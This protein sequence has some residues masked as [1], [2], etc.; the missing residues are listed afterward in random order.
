VTDA[1]ETGVLVNHLYLAHGRE[2][3]YPFMDEGIVR[4]SFAFEPG[5]RYRKG[6][7]VKPLLK[8]ILEQHSLSSI[9][10]KPKGPSVFND[11]LYDWM[12]NGSMRDMVRSIE[13]P[14]F[15]SQSD[16]RKLL[17]VPDWDPLDEPNWFLWNLLTFDLFQKRVVH[18]GYFR[19]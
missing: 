4:I 2:Q 15:L 6:Q 18:G 9:A 3:I 8:Q 5:I 12:R 16:F 19:S 7:Q 10:H 14:S 13:R 1:Y 17:M 11:D